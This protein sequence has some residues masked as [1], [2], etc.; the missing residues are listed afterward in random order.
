MGRVMKPGFWNVP[1]EWKG[2]TAFVIAGGT[3]VAKQDISKLKGR[4]VIVVNSSYEVAP[5]ADFLFFGDERW[6]HDHV[7]KP[8]ILQFK[9]RIVTPSAAAIGRSILRVRRYTPNLDKR[10][11]KLGPGLTDNRGAVVSQRTSLQGAINLAVHLGVARIVLLGADMCRGESGKTHHHSPHKWQNKPGNATWNI[12]MEQLALVVE[13]LRAWGIE[14]LNASPISR[15]P[16]WPKIGFEDVL[17]EYVCRP[18]ISSA[19]GSCDAVHA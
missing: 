8:G 16:W 13:P 15:I 2:E 3:S 12:Q 1:P 11:G 14:V 19:I 6:W 4:R 10:R 7:K 18:T 17:A 5:W 9:G